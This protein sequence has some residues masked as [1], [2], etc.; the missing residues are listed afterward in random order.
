VQS[1]GLL[2]ALRIRM[3]I[4]A[5]NATGRDSSR[6]ISAVALPFIPEPVAMLGS[7]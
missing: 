6:M 1:R 7:G 2:T 4:L 5:L 3:C